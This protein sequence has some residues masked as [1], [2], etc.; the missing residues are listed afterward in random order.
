MDRAAATCVQ[1]HSLT[2]R[3]R[4]A[5]VLGPA[6]D[7]LRDLGIAIPAADRVSAELDHQFDYLYR[8]LDRNDRADDLSVPDLGESTLLAASRLINAVLPAAYV[9]DPALYAWLS[10]ETL[11][12]W[13]ERGPGR[14]LLG[15]A[16]IAAFAAVALRSDYA[17]GYRAARRHSGAGRGSRLRTRDL[18][19]TLRVRALGLLVRAHRRRRRR[20]S[21]GPGGFDR[22]RR[23]GQCRIHIPDGRAVP[24]GLRAIARCLRCRRRGRAGVRQTYG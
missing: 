15:P 12:I 21:A 6:F 18:A 3:N 17:A 20:C 2:H 8:W 24:L 7:S 4:F 14:T 13:L 11:R 5:E 19:R 16:S 1:V 23:P 9:A 22:R 10:L